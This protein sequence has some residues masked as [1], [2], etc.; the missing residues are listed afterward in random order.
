MGGFHELKIPAWR[1][2]LPPSVPVLLSDGAGPHLIDHAGRLVL[3]LADHPLLSG[4]RV[5]MGPC[6]G[7]EQIGIVVPEAAAPGIW[8]WLGR[9]R[10]AAA[11]RLQTLEDRPD[12][13]TISS[14]PPE[15]IPIII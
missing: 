8:R 11:D 2:E 9:A 6:D 5:A 13:S 12:A 14:P 4:A 15:S 1:A 3:A 7:E 10:V